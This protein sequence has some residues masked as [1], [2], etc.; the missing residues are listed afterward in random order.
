MCNHYRYDNE[1]RQVLVTKLIVLRRKKTLPET[2]WI[3]AFER[4]SEHPPV[5]GEDTHVFVQQG[6]EVVPRLI[7]VHG[8]PAV[9]GSGSVCGP[10][11]GGSREASPDVG[12]G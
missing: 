10:D 6:L 2:H 4:S 12:C 1:D 11:M 9:L 5:G 8:G 3:C 7:L